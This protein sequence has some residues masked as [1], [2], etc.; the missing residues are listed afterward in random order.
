[1]RLETE[2]LVLRP[3]EPRDAPVVERE[4]SRV[5]IARMM[6]IPHPYP[7]GGA[8]EWIAT[9]K[10]GRDFAIE[11]R[12]T[13]ELVG[14]I[15]ITP[16]EQ[17]RRASLG[18]WCAVAH[19]GSGYTTEA[20]LAIVDYGFRELALNRVH[21]DCYTDNPASRRVLEKAGMA[22]EG[23]LRQHSFR[24]G[25]FADKLQ[26]GMLRSEWETARGR[27]DGEAQD[28]AGGK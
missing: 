28:L 10:P 8:A 19:W 26:F 24:L 15:T 11:L 21:A 9:T 23:C 2:R 1:V 13:G 6:N 12:E 7:K 16:H 20:V 3:F 4:V 17:H 14:A 5:E 25:R 27:P 18:Y 22:Y